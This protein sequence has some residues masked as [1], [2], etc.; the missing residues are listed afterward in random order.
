[1]SRWQRLM[2]ALL[3]RTSTRVTSRR[4]AKF[5]CSASGV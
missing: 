3:L 2:V 4:E 5:I 1:L